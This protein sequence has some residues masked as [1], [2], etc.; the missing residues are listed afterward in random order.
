[1]Q[2]I[3][4]DEFSKREP[5]STP[6]CCGSGCTV[7]VLDYPEYGLEEQSD[8]NMQEMIE[9]IE[10]AQWQAQELIAQIDGESQ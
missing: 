6:P 1:M 2:D 3:E 8:E 4:S 9:A 7:C 10:K 5:F